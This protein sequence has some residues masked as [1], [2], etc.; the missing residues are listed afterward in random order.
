VPRCGTRSVALPMQSRRIDAVESLLIRWTS[1]LAW[2]RWATRRHLATLVYRPAA[3]P[4]LDPG[5]VPLGGIRRSHG[6]GSGVLGAAGTS[7]TSPRHSHRMRSRSPDPQRRAG[8]SGSRSMWIACWWD[9]SA[10]HHPTSSRA[11]LAFHGSAASV[12]RTRSSASRLSLR[13]GRT[14][15]DT[16]RET[17]NVRG[18]EQ[19]PCSVSRSRTKGAVSVSRS[20]EGRDRG[21]TS[22]R[23]TD[24]SPGGG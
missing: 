23:S 12:G 4:A 2:L 14:V 9:S 18:A 5:A 11:S 21:R 24:G 19:H 20:W 1:L 10:N 6:W 17:R 13:C 16:R 22:L 7:S 15:H 8:V 3:Q